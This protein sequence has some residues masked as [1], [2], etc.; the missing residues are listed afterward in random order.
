MNFEEFLNLLRGWNMNPPS[1]GH[2]IIA[3]T[4]G[5]GKSMLVLYKIYK[6]FLYNRPCCYI[7]PKGDTYRNLLLFFGFTEEGRRLWE[8]FAHRIVL[9]NP[10]TVSDHIVGFNAIEPF[11]DF[12]HAHPDQVA[13]L[14]NSIVSHIKRQSNF[15]FSD[16]NRMQ[17]IMSAA[18]GTLVQGGHGKLTLAELP[19][20][21]VQTGD[22]SSPFNP[23][24]RRLLEDVTHFGTRSFWQH[25]WAS[26]TPS[27][28]REWVQS[29][30]GRI[31][32]YLFD[33]RMLATVCTTQKSPLNFRQIVDEGKWVFV[34]APYGQ[35]TETI[36]TLLGN[37]IV[38]NIFY[39]C[40][41]R[42]PAGRPYRLILDEARFFNTGPLEL[43]LETS[44]AY[45]LWLT[46]VVQSLDQMCRVGNGAVDVRLKETAL[47]NARYLS[48]FN[49]V[50][51]RE[52]LA[53]TIC[54]VVQPKV[55]ELDDGRLQV[56]P[57]Q[58]E[59]ARREQSF[60]TLQ[61]RQVVLY[62]KFNGSATRAWTPTF[63]IG[64]ADQ[65]QIDY[66]ESKHL[67]LTGVPIA[68]IMAEINDRQNKYNRMLYQ[69]ATQQKPQSAPPTQRYHTPSKPVYGGDL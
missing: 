43:I 10:L 46:V 55:I 8:R 62:D 57:I 65:A 23:V 52:L 29:T 66:F 58:L 21:F 3:G 32:Q 59:Q 25:Q 54:P 35:L 44:R 39:A 36:T 6:S 18:I 31:F 69:T 68:S 11:G 37:L 34:N 7:D 63:N 45:S 1:Q 60:A 24:V 2:E 53:E 49:D 40:M 14:A 51:D 17:N 64:Q 61:P 20:L 19:L 26:W 48:V 15:E 27:A 50:A 38:T 41:Q 9:V 42:P 28:R 33:S 5:M 56:E 67:A 12:L 30:E 16:A 47:N 4:I 13:L 22:K